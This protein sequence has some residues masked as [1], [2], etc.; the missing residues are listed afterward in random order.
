MNNKRKMKKKI[1]VEI[2]REKRVEKDVYAL[3]RLA[4]EI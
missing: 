3:W 4:E 2:G 1:F